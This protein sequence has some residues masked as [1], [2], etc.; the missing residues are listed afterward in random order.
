V[1]VG[2]GLDDVAAEGE[3]VNDGSAEAGSVKV[4]VQPEK[5][6]LE[7]MATLFFSS[8]SVRTWKRSS[9]PPRALAAAPRGCAACHTT[10]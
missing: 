4:L 6:S 3:A 9:A 10:A 1:G 5:D 7:A 8:R 2:A